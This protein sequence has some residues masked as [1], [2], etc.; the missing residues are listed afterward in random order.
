M[1]GHWKRVKEF[2]LKPADLVDLTKGLVGSNRRA[3]RR[4][5]SFTISI[6]SLGA[7]L[8]K[9]DGRVV[10]EE[11]QA[12]REIFQIPQHE[13]KNAAKVFNYASQNPVG[14]EYYALEIRKLVGSGSPQ[15]KDIMEGLIYIACSDG[16]IT[17]QER[18]FLTR[19]NA[20]FGLPRRQFRQS[21]NYYGQGNAID[22]Y[23]ILGVSR[24][25]P[26]NEIKKVWRSLVLQFHPDALKS[27]GI[28]QEA[29][30]V[31]ELQLARFNQ[32]WKVIQEDKRLE[33]CT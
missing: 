24:D 3:R 12:F 14:Y 30:R 27:R 11:I 13:K 9:I 21:L 4:K 29:V 26:L 25:M 31:S 33:N 7:K 22:P 17:F 1:K 23:R 18:R 10:R 15:L 6:I 28:P 32:A 2:L 8:A 20:I 16:D 19:V 5:I